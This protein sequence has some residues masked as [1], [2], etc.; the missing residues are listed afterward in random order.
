MLS[1]S[2]CSR[3]RWRHRAQNGTLNAPSTVEGCVRAL[4]LAFSYA[5]WYTISRP[6][7]R[8]ATQSAA[9]SVWCASCVEPATRQHQP[10]GKY[11]AC[12]Q[13]RIDQNIQ[14]QDGIESTDTARFSLSLF[15]LRSLFLCSSLNTKRCAATYISILSPLFAVS[16]EVRLCRAVLCVGCFRQQFWRAR[17]R[18]LLFDPTSNKR[19]C[20]RGR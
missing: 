10:K 19:Q 20:R 12:L 11:V 17:A 1:L 18:A 14:T 7:R 9:R 4:S 5:D 8:R 3:S 6:R 2:L 16:V 15:S 13:Y